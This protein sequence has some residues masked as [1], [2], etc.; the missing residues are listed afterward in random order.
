MASPLFRPA[1]DWRR[2]SG[3]LIQ[4][5]VNSVRSILPISRSALASAFWR[6]YDASLLRM[7]D[8]A[9]VPCGWTRPCA[10]LRPSFR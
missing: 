3:S 4:F 5:R 10:A 2:K 1:C 7:T 9:T 6:G 8:G